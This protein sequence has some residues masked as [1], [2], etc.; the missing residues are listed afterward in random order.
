MGTKLSM[1]AQII[2]FRCLLK[3]AAGKVIS[4]SFNRE[5]LTTPDG[6]GAPLKALALALHG[7][8]K[9]EQRSIY[10][11][12]DEAYGFYDL[13]KVILYPLKKIPDFKSAK[14]GQPVAIMSKT[15]VLRHYVIAQIQG[16][17]VS[18]DGNHP[19]A[20]QDLI[21]EI[22]ATDARMATPDEVEDS[23]GVPVKEWL[24]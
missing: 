23:I 13:S 21:F 10:L 9:G 12:A 14:V 4:S 5:V 6:D 11:K 18:L 19:L 3:N 17:W 24:H 20:G 16:E 8:K 7:L 1:Q 15:G 2:S 22:E